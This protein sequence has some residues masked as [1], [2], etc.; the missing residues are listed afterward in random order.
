MIISKCPLRVS[1]AGGSTDLQKFVDEFGRGAVINFPIDV[2]TY[3]FL[4]QSLDDQYKIIYSKIEK[5][6]NVDEIENEI[7]REVI[8][9]FD[10]SPVTIIFNADIP[11]SGS[12]LAS[13]SSYTVAL[14]ECVNRYLDLNLSQFDVCKVALSIERTVNPLTGYQDTYGC[15]LSGGVKRLDITNDKIKIT[16][17]PFTMSYNMYLINT[18]V[19]R[20]STSILNSIQVASSKTLLNLVDQIEDNIDNQDIIC[21]YLN[22]GWKSKKQSSPLICT[23]EITKL[24]KK[25]NLD[26][27]VKG[28]KLC[29]AGGG[30]YFLVIYDG[31]NDDGLLINIDTEGVRSFTI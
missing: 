3:I 13:S 23:D 15:G 30:G 22:K 11:T 25:I 29:G 9:Y 19:V 27:S 5:T 31:I 14:V 6:D 18:G 20:S 24:D 17:L 2:Y 7:A 12:G 28:V 1:L 16:Y 8:R 26:N 10:L 21:R 4:D